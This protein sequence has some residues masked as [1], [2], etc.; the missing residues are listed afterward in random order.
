MTGINF[1]GAELEKIR[2]LNSRKNSESSEESSSRSW[3]ARKSCAS[4][5]RAAFGGHTFRDFSSASQMNAH[6][7]LA[8]R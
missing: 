3:A 7:A 4:A 5:D 6:A 8:A 2:S 1:L